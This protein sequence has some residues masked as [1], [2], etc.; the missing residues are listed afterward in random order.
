[1]ELIV[2]MVIMMVVISAV[3]ALMRGTIIGANANYEVTTA[4]QSLRNAQEYI[5]RDALV[6][7]DGFKSI[8]NIWLPTSFVTNYLTA[9]S[10][11]TLDPSNAGFLSVGSVISDDN[12]AAGKT[13]LNTT[14]STN[15]LP[16]TDR[17]TMLSVDP[18]FSSVPLLA[19]SA[20]V[21]NGEITIP[22]GNTSNYAVGE[23][24]HI[25]GG[26][27]G[28]F[29]IIT[30]IT[31]GKIVWGESDAFGLNHFGATGNIGTATGGNGSA[32]ATLT[33]VNIIHYF[34]DASGK[35]IRRAF[36][37][38]GAPFVDSV[39]AEHV[40]NLQFRYTLQP[41]VNG[42]IYR[43]PIA[44]L[45]LTD[46]SM[47]RMIESAVEI[48]TANELQD[49]QKSKVDGVTEIGVRNLQF[50]QAPVPYDA[51]GNTTLPN[52]GPTPFMTPLPT[53]SPTPS[54]TP[55]PTATPSPTPSPTPGGTPVPTPTPIPTPTP[56]PTPT[57]VPT[58]TPT[59]TPSTGEGN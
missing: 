2:V 7:G 9:R 21:T 13:V 3:F 48:E 33:R 50:M 23:I 41:D 15:V 29:G 38:K 47:V 12:V 18:S 46:A 32:P 34:V 45:A 8:S 57:P 17:I 40:K 30:S 44:Q 35:L 27:N 10:A 52:P 4:S 54:P 6:V 49:G 20:N 53:P 25:S 1:M 19:G 24:Y 56:T 55:V 39:I 22:G 42:T 43:A 37:V 14:P 28:A 5:S 58:P 31:G 59:P 16:T 11:A 36:G 26:G 51:Q